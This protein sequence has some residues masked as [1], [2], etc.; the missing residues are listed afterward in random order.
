MAQ[1]GAEFT[2]L[3][4][5][6]SFTPT[7]VPTQ[8]RSII[9]ADYSN[10]LR[11]I[12]SLG[13]RLQAAPE[14]MA[15]AKSAGMANRLMDYVSNI[16]KPGWKRDPGL[17][18]M[19]AM[20]SVQDGRFGL[21]PNINIP[22]AQRSLFL[23]TLGKPPPRE[24]PPAPTGQDGGGNGGNSRVTKRAGGID[25]PGQK[26]NPN[27]QD[28]SSQLSTA[29]VPDPRLTLGATDQTGQSG[30]L[31]GQIGQTDQT[32]AQTGQ[33]SQT[34]TQAAQSAQTTTQD[35]DDAVSWH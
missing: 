19:L 28:F 9:P 4:L 25:Q 13:N 31:S 2:P 16:G 6:Y 1:P 21:S 26:Y 27:P 23:S 8:T 34:G 3:G 11:G 18:Y 10:L 32:G 15:K 12:E 22:W 17:D 5:G 35:G 30:L 29:P 14:M 7:T 20:G 24:A 33:S